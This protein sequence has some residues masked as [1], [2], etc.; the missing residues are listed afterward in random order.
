M[1]PLRLHVA[2]PL[3]VHD[4]DWVL[5]P[6]RVHVLH[7]LWMPLLAVLLTVIRCYVPSI[8]ITFYGFR[9]S[10]MIQ[11]FVIDRKEMTRHR[12]QGQTDNLS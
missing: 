8:F 5:H 4:V 12:R 10:L 2:V 3:R 6:R 1:E 7:F 11:A 9:K